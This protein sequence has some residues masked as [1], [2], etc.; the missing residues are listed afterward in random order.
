MQ[1]SPSHTPSQIPLSHSHIH[2]SSHVP[3]YTTHPYIPHN[4]SHIIYPIH[5]RISYKSSHIPH[6][7]TYPMYIPPPPLQPQAQAPHAPVII[8]GTHLDKVNTRAQKQEL[9]QSLDYIAKTY[10]SEDHR[11]EGFPQV[12]CGALPHYDI[13][14]YLQNNT[15][16]E[17][18]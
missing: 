16:H 6:T 15:K 7:L 17:S 2:T 14:M 13:T 11:R 5:P 3:C 4:H 12:G 8:V 1:I 18:G 9:S 10:G